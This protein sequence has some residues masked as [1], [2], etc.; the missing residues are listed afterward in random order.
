[1]T[2]EERKAKPT[3]TKASLEKLRA[4]AIKMAHQSQQ[5]FLPGSHQHGIN[6]PRPVGAPIAGHH[7]A[8][9][10]PMLEKM[11]AEH[12]TQLTG[13]ASIMPSYS[14]MEMVSNPVGEYMAEYPQLVHDI[15]QEVLG[16][17]VHQQGTEQEG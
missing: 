2:I 9:I 12:R 3:I 6:K 15:L 1:M 10:Q 17:E 5:P 8:A 14:L 11:K 16:I 7:L 13:W 4:H